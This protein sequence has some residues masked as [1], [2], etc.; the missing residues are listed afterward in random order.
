MPLLADTLRNIALE[1]QEKSRK[2]TIDRY[3]E[4]LKKDIRIAKD[5]VMCCAG[6]AASRGE[7]EF[8]V[9]LPGDLT[10]ERF[11]AWLYQQGF[12]VTSIQRVYYPCTHAN[13]DTPSYYTTEIT[14]SFARPQQQPPQEPS[15]E[16]VTA[17][18]YQ[19]TGVLQRSKESE[20]PASENPTVQDT[21]NPVHPQSNPQSNPARFPLETDD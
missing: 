7:M 12:H 21:I 20:V 10:N 9:T 14:A 16:W 4:K 1:A 2:V 18:V 17:N 19:P 8:T 11:S 5:N 6:D 13:D 15:Q 3:I